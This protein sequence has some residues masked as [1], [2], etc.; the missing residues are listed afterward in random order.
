M[1]SGLVVKLRGENLHGACLEPEEAT[2]TMFFYQE[3]EE[4]G[5]DC[6]RC[7]KPLR[8]VPDA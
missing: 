6:Q 3:G 2:V 4:P 5:G 1:I 7:G 8:E